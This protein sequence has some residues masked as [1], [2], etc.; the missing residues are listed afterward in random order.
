M[1]NP[2]N[3]MAYGAILISIAL[4]LLLMALFITYLQLLKKYTN[5]KEEKS[6]IG[7]DAQRQA[8]SLIEQARRQSASILG[9]SQQKAA[10]IIKEAG[11]ISQEARQKMI[12]E[13]S[14][15]TQG[16]AKSYQELLTEVKNEALAI[17]NNISQSIKGESA[18]E[19]EMMK[20]ALTGEIVKAQEIT[21]KAITESIAKI[22]EEVK[23]NKQERIKKVDTAIF[24]IIRE[25]SQKVIGRSFNP[26]EHE[27]LVIKSLDEAKKEH[28]L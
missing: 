13:M 26:Q 6:K 20:Q 17:V 10:N 23:V 22:E 11:V 8:E 2:S 15:V 9:E 27:D 21:R 19:I 24:D 12:T 14:R 28:V 16:Y 7:E 3:I 4:G 5:L 18:K 1:N 25:A